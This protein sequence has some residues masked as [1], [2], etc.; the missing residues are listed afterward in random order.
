MIA[1]LEFG[2]KGLMI[3]PHIMVGI[4]ERNNLAAF[5]QGLISS[6][7]C[8]GSEMALKFS[9]LDTVGSIRII[10]GSPLD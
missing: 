3:K 8:F 10:R 6:G 1:G 9:L 2:C 5:R 7:A 4:N